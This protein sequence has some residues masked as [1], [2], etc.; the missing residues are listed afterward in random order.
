MVTQ[1]ETPPV[2]WATLWSVATPVG[3][4][5]NRAGNHK[6]Y[7]WAKDAAG[8][9]SGAVPELAVNLE[10]INA[11]TFLYVA[12]GSTGG[13]DLRID[14][15]KINPATGVLQ[16]TYTEV[17]PGSSS[18]ATP[19]RS[20]KG[21]LVAHPNAKFL[22]HIGVDEDSVIRQFTIRDDGS[23][24]LVSTFSLDPHFGPNQ[25]W[26]GQQAVISPSG[27]VFFLSTMESMPELR[28]FTIDSAGG[29]TAAASS[30]LGALLYSMTAMPNGFLVADQIQTNLGVS[31]FSYLQTGETSSAY[32]ER[33]F[34]MAAVGDPLG[35]YVYSSHVRSGHIQTRTVNADGTLSLSGQV[36][37][38]NHEGIPLASDPDGNFLYV[39]LKSGRAIRIYNS[40]NSYGA[41]KDITAGFSTN[42][43]LDMLI[44]STGTLAFVRTGDQSGMNLLVYRMDP[45]DLTLLTN[46]PGAPIDGYWGWGDGKPVVVG[47]H[48]GNDPPVTNAGVDRWVQV[49]ESAA[50][51]GHNTFDP[52]AARCAADTTKYVA[53]WNFVSKPVASGLTDSDIIG[54][55]TLGS[56]R[57]I[58]DVPGDYKLRLTFT[59]DPGSCQG[60]AKTRTA[61]VTIKAGYKHIAPAS[62]WDS[63]GPR[64]N[65]EAVWAEM[66]RLPVHFGVDTLWAFVHF[67]SEV[68]Y[69][70]CL[71]LA[72]IAYGQCN[73]MAGRLPLPFSAALFATCTTGYALANASCAAQYLGR[74][75]YTNICQSPIQPAIMA[76]QYCEQRDW[77]RDFPNSPYLALYSGVR[78]H[79]FLHLQTRDF[80]GGQWSWF[81]YSPPATPPA[82][83]FPS[84]EWT[85]F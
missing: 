72:G 1:T 76:W 3:F 43:P 34:T 83:N 35:R 15:L 55:N 40:G 60:T 81:D 8:N 68:L 62:Y 27:N 66:L 70:D 49:S 71:A 82:I 59:D 80:I 51:H 32:T 56:A 78:G 7:A 11:P 20:E 12:R 16:P 41:V 29:L 9:V 54:A 5:F 31:S 33:D 23:L 24:Q 42:G 57:F 52:D 64:P 44:D 47:S 48:D 38:G 17:L 28:T 22:Y 53:V 79:F 67:R 13:A 77:V 69:A 14:V 37:L 25:V 65:P 61:L 10:G 21:S 26:A 39:G 75:S 58:P 6:L 2:S 45:G 19:T 85:P 63:V 74:Y 73:T 46:N 18:A 50:L 4:A 84:V 36:Y 30:P